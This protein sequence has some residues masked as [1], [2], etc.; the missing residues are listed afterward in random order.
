MPTG[1]PVLRVRSAYARA[2]RCG[3]GGAIGLGCAVLTPRMMLPGVHGS[4]LRRPSLGLHARSRRQGR[5]GTTALP[6]TKCC[7]AHSL[8]VLSTIAYAPDSLGCTGCARLLRG[9]VLTCAMLL[10]GGMGCSV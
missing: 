10:G 7:Y 4:V 2:T 6:P 5:P 8:T 1:F 3:T 9:L